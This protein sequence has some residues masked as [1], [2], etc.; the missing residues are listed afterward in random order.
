MC[1][2]PRSKIEMAGRTDANT[3]KENCIRMQH[4]TS[5]HQYQAHVSKPHRDKTSL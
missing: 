1:A 5:A 3:P 2:Y 4:I